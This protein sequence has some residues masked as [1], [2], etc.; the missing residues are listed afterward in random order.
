MGEASAGNDDPIN[1]ELTYCH[2]EEVWRS[3]S[4][5]GAPHP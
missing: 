1:K 3:V 2:T 5:V 4:G